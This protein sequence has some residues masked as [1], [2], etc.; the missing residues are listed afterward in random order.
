MFAWNLGRA[1][2]QDIRQVLQFP[3][4]G[5]EPLTPIIGPGLVAALS[6]SKLFPARTSLEGEENQIFALHMCRNL[7]RCT[8]KISPYMRLTTNTLRYSLPVIQIFL[9]R[10]VFD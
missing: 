3:F 2:L 1:A 9:P 5:V 6:T 10:M 4:A 7:E 8:E